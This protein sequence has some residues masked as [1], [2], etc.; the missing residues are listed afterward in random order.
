VI[1]IMKCENELTF[2]ICTDEARFDFH[3]IIYEEDILTTFKIDSFET[4]IMNYF[5]VED[6]PDYF[7]FEELTEIETLIMFDKYK[8]DLIK[9]CNKK[10]KEFLL[11]EFRSLEIV[12]I[13][14]K[15][16]E[17]CNK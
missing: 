11:R 16:L 2:E 12:E 14:K 3:I 5:S 17:N 8:N 4:T 10:S 13:F 15:T 7:A 6:L 1:K 9:M